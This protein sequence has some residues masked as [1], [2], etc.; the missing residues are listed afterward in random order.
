MYKKSENEGGMKAEQNIIILVLAVVELLLVAEL[1][2]VVTLLDGVFLDGPEGNRNSTKD[3]ETDQDNTDKE[4]THAAGLGMDGIVSSRGSITDDR[5]LDDRGKDTS[6]V[7]DKLVET[8]ET[9]SLV[10]IVGQGSHQPVRETLVHGIGDSV[11]EVEE[12]G[13][14][15]VLGV[16]DQID[17]VKV[18]GVL[19]QAARVA[20]VWDGVVVAG[21]KRAL[22]E[23]PSSPGTAKQDSQEDK[24]VAGT[25][26]TGPL[27]LVQE[28]TIGNGGENLSQPVEHRVHG[29]R[30]DGEVEGVDGVEL[31][32][33]DPVGGEEHG[34]QAQHAPVQEELEDR[35]QLGGGARVADTDD[36]RAI[37]TENLGG[38]QQEEGE[39]GTN[40][41]DDH[42]GP[43][44]TGAS[45]TG[46]GVVPLENQGDDVTNDTSTVEDGPED[47]KVL[48]LVTL[49]GVAHH[50]GTL[51]APQPT[52]T[53]T[54]QARGND[55][56]DDRG[57]EVVGQ[58]G[59]DIETVS[60]TTDDEQETVTKD[61]EESAGK[62]GRDGKDTGEGSRGMVSDI[63]ILGAETIGSC[64]LQGIEHA[65]TAKTDN[66]LFFE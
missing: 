2:Y 64:S 5:G 25:L 52:G 41:H 1:D 27:A 7:L 44:G 63:R 40:D 37:P 34:D 48:A 56:K 21:T 55:N 29:T 31:V 35:D 53:N 46:I 43:I 11:S 10:G 16:G 6:Q 65:W 14:D 49:L 36:V 50:D 58:E 13:T 9:G 59:S 3:T 62:E 22:E 15:K 19:D 20:R 18:G 12:E 51:G 17:M 39:K 61:V 30:T 23:V 45:T 47:G 4:L 28:L 57:D 26:G 38:R 33:V 54:E 24:T 60:Q 42:V 66:A 8:S 32:G